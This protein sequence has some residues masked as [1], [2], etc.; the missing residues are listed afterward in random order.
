GGVLHRV[1]TGDY[2][3]A[4]RWKVSKLEAGHPLPQPVALFK[5]LDDIPDDDPGAAAAQEILA[6]S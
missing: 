6:S 3:I 4:D 5:R 2:P 1:I